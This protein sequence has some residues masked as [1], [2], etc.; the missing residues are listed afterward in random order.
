M[1][2]DD[3]VND[4]AKYQRGWKGGLPETPCGFGSKLS[5]TAIQRDTLQRWIR[6]HEI[7]SIA[8]IGAGDL[9]WASHMDLDRVEYIP[10][11]LV[12]RHPDVVEFD[13][14]GDRPIPQVDMIWCLWVL[15]HLT[16]PQA[17]KAIA[18]LIYSSGA[19]WLVMTW[20]RR[21]FDFLNVA[22]EETVVIRPKEKRT[23]LE[24]GDVE[25]RLIRNRAA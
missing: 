13:L 11:D 18:R 5:E 20:E 24:F 1:K 17:R 23:K 4:R 6:Q 2:N 19:R 10:L 14:L 25:L 22:A 16:E 9:N 21:M 12:P 15:N 8:D 3:I 7:T